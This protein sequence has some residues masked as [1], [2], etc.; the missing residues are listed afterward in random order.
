LKATPRPSRA[1]LEEAEAA[2]A[3]M[4]LRHQKED[5]AL[6]RKE[7]ALARERQKMEARHAAEAKRIEKARD[8]AERAYRLALRN[9]QG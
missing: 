2:L 4:Q 9:W 8:E 1:D 6:A 3:A 7:Q 5:G